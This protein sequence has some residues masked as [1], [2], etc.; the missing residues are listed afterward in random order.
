M[1]GKKLPIVEQQLLTTY[2]NYSMQLCS[3]FGNEN[4]TQWKYEHFT[5]LYLVRSENNYIWYDYL[6][7]VKYLKDIVDYKYCRADE[8]DVEVNYV[9][10]MKEYIDNE[11]YAM[12]YLDLFFYSYSVEYQNKHDAR[13]FMIYGYDDEQEVF[14]A[15]GF[16]KVKQ[17]GTIIIPYADLDIGVKACILFYEKMPI[18]VN[19]YCFTL[20]KIIYKDKIYQYNPQ[21]FINHLTDFVES[22]DLKDQLRPENKLV[23]GEEAVCG[24]ATEY[25]YIKGLRELAEGNFVT[26]Y[27]HIHLLTEHK[28]MMG[29]KLEAVLTDLGMSKLKDEIEPSFKQ[30]INGFNTQRLRVLRGVLRDSNY[31][32]GQLK[33]KKDIV[34][35]A[36]S[37]E[38]LIEKEEAIYK[39]ILSNI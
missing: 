25:E 3:V 21:I 39:K 2:L 16:D 28:R 37:V 36:D 24:I 12:I 23:F 8:L 1:K 34:S 14:Y 5:N 29:V 11:Y 33:V 15:I 32:Y 30:V 4:L 6:E 19:W 20:H 35:I 13:A 26:D 7:E 27:R 9:E 22:K 38:A 17:F 31:M 10:K 18:W